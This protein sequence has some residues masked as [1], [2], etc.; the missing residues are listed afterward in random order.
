MVVST[1]NGRK[2]HIQGFVGGR[3]PQR[4]KIGRPQG[5]VKV[6]LKVRSAIDYLQAPGAG[7]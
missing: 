6:K 5:V 4:P 7:G 2:H 1:Y 3:L